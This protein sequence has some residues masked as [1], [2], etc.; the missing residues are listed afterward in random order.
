[1]NAESIIRQADQA[2][3]ELF[4][5]GDKIAARPKSK[6]SADLREL[7]K[8]HREEIIRILRG[9][10]LPNFTRLV[11]HYGADHGALLEDSTIRNELDSQGMADLQA[12]S[13]LARQSWAESIATRLVLQ[14]GKC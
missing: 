12:T 2:G 6:L 7:I 13:T 1:M 8:T 10:S 4:L 11:Q 5:A 3:I 14:V 9:F